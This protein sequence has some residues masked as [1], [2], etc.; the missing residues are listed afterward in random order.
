[1]GGAGNDTYVMAR[2]NG[3]D[4]VFEYDSTSGNT[5]VAEFTGGIDADQLWF[6]RA[7]SSLEVSVIGSNDLLRVS[8]WYSDAAYHVEQLRSSDGKTL[9]DSQ[10]QNLVDAMAAFTPP[11]MGQM[12][13]SDPYATVLAPV[14]AA[15]WQ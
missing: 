15:N 14:L 4:T 7:G 1:M 2:G 8:G 10:V 11:A 5:D 12:H 13:L 3:V 9:L 6:R